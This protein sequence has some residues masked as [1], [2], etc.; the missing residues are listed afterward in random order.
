M[1]EGEPAA[2]QVVDKPTAHGSIRE[3]RLISTILECLSGVACMRV[4]MGT[5]V[6]LAIAVLGLQLAATFASAQ[7]IT[8][9]GSEIA[10]QVQAV[11]GATTVHLHNLS[12]LRNGSYHAANASSIKLPPAVGGPGQR[13]YF[14]LPEAGTTILGRRYGYFVDHVRSTG[15]FVSAAPDSFTITI[16]LGSAGPALVGTCARIKPPQIACATLGADALPAIEWRDARVDIVAR[17]MVFG[18]SLAMDVQSVTLGGDF[19]VG[20][21]CQFPLLGTRLCAAVNRQS[22][23]MRQSLS[24][25]IK[26]E[27]NTAAVRTTTAA[28]VRAYLDTTLTEPLI[29]IRRVSMQDGQVRIGVALGR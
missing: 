29:G 14:D 26:A 24:E 2:T 1:P 27:L 18:R 12:P 20:G 13:T 28:A 23:R 21:T 19:D 11:L 15:V 25:R 22:V 3:R 5:S 17:P 4:E 6:R 7:Q 8:L 10:T 9:A 16:T